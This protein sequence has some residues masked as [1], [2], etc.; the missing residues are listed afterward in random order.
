[1][2]QNMQQPCTADVDGFLQQMENC[3]SLVLELQE[4]VTASS[5]FHYVVLYAVYDGNYILFSIIVRQ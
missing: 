1:M 2:I 4:K 5:L 3:K